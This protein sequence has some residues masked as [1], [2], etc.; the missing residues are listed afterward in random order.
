LFVS[1]ELAHYATVLEELFHQEVPVPRTGKQGRPRQSERVIAPDL[2]YATVHKTRQNGRVVQVERHVI[3]GSEASIQR[4]LADSPSHTINTA[5]VERT[6]QDWR[7]WDAH[8]VRKG[9]T[10]ARSIRWLRAK[11]AIVIAVYDLVRPHETLSRGEDRV[12]RPMTPV[13]AAKATDHPWTILELIRYPVL[14]Q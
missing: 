5:Y 3:Y 2:D 10:F 9:L 11:F 6:N 8:L 14:C 7:L 1:D 4:R 12:F 13:M